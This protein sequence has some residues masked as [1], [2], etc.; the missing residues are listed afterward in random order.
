LTVPAIGAPR[1]GPSELIL[2]AT[3]PRAPRNLL[4]RSRLASDDAQFRDRAVV[5]VQAP[6]GFGKTSLLAQWRREYL[7][8]GAAVAWM[9]AHANDDPQRLVQGLVFAVRVG[10]GR[11]TFGQTLVEGAAPP[12]ELEGITAW[13]AELSQTALDV[14]LIVDDAERLPAA[15]V[16]GALSY[17][18]HN[19]PP[20]LRVVVAARA[21]VDL[22]VD[23]L[24]DYGQCVRL[25]A[26][27]LRFSLAETI[28]LVRARCG[29]R[30]DAD[31]CA[32][33][34]EA[35]EGWPLGL[36]LTLAAIERSADPSAAIRAM[37]A[38][39]GDPP[40][41][42]LGG[43][44]SNL[45]ADDAAF[46]TRVA[47]VDHLHP[48]LCRA[49]TGAADAAERLAR[50]VRD[51][52]VLV[53]V[54]GSE[55]VR[56][57]VLARDVLRGRFA[58]LPAAEQGP[59]R[60]HA[61]RWL[62]DHGLLEEAARQ[63]FEAGQ[64][65]LA[66]DLA[67]K[68]LYDAMIRGRQAAVLD[69][70]DRLPEAEIDRRPRLR[71]AVAWAL[72]LSDRHEEA[73]REVARILEQPRI[74]DALRY[75]CA[76]ILSG[77]AYYADEPDRFIEIFAPWVDAPP[78]HDPWLLRTHANR[79]AHRALLM[80]DP[81][82]ARLI[83][84]RA[85]RDGSGPAFSFVA[86]WGDFVIGLSR[87]W[88]G[89]VRLVDETLRPAVADAEATLGRRAPLSCM[90]ATVLAAAVWEL[91]RPDEATA[92]LANRLDVLER[93][94]L[95]ETLLLAYR[96]LARIA[97]AEGGEHRALDL[98][99]SMHAAGLAR[100]LPR[101]C[102]ASLADQVRVHARRFRPETC[103][104]LCARID[105]FL[106]RDDLPQGELWQRSVEVLRALAGANAAIAAQDWPRAI[107]TLQSAGALAEA[108][109]LGRMRI[110]IMALRAFAL[111]RN[112]ETAGLPLLRE[113]INLAETY[114][115]SRLFVD[116]HPALGE[117]ARRV[118]E[119]AGAGGNVSP[120]PV[121]APRGSAG[122]TGQRAAV[123]PR[124]MPSMILTPK[125]REVLELLARNLSNKEIALAMEV[126]EETVKWHLKNLFG[127]LSAGT[128]KQVV[129][130][131][132]LLGLLE[133]AR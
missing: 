47:V 6:A 58:A 27:A 19:A 95:P 51:T 115:L 7:A 116:A 12:G 18:L 133:E 67:E 112:A 93:A 23:D 85:P 87:L 129:R 99:E 90:L 3:P 30:V 72:A 16:H 64:G 124:A 118:A 80:G 38:R 50:L 31:E 9:A 21:E 74:D 14:V 114:G 101:L 56:L 37:S 122:P 45:E 65:E 33:L 81:A 49:M 89:Q 78:A 119:G 41:H 4:V 34:H 130:R 104:S 48:G 84:V 113:A 127:K 126:G 20:N 91:D 75:E 53:A 42:L 120:H 77:A 66:Y 15:T 110:E 128:R 60:V 106:A 43:L 22:G 82:E 108:L 39:S 11:P 32:R 88:E 97:A 107:Q 94:G 111:D 62:A 13:L 117:W 59:I 57:H 24:V 102:I 8:R 1:G 69:W 132:Q 92:L 125:E 40:E 52:P 121:N 26:A 131:A 86:R 5:V 100:K 105:E 2:K 46:L 73:G 96:T 35:T 36:Q 71:L 76:L 17:L 25:G 103:R 98:L 83:E 61:A 55:W 70:L 109:K 28:E 44:L 29:G 123:P 10:C 54:E 68:C 79:L 63:A